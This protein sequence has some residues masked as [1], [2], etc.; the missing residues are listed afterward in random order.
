MPENHLPPLQD[1]QIDTEVSL[2]S[3]LP[4]AGREENC[5][6][7]GGAEAHFPNPPPP[8]LAAVTG[9]GVQGGGA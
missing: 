7:G 5:S 8:S 6:T 3:G 9:G 2:A 4:T 1:V